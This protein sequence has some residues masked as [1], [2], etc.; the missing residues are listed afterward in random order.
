MTLKQ[1]DDFISG[2]KYG[3]CYMVFK[4]DTFENKIKE[5]WT[6]A[7]DGHGGF[8]H[9]DWDKTPD[10]NKEVIAFKPSG[11]QVNIFYVVLK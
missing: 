11:W 10:A 5:I 8:Y 6:K 3:R 7:H 2:Y 1:L 4:D 9:A